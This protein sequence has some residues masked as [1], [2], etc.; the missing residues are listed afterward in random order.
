MGYA[1]E[2]EYFNPT[3]IIKKLFYLIYNPYGYVKP[4]YLIAS[5]EFTAEFAESI[6]E[7]DDS[8]IMKLG[9]P[10]T[11]SL[12]NNGEELNEKVNILINKIIGD[13]DNN[14]ILFLPTFRNNPDYDLF[15]FDF[16][17][18]QLEIFLNN[19]NL[20]LLINLHPFDKNRFEKLSG[21]KLKR[22]I[23]LNLIGDELNL[24]LRK[25]S[26]FITDYSSLWADFLIYNCPII[27]AQYDH[28]KYLTERKVYNLQNNLPVHI[29]KNWPELI[30]IMHNIVIDGD[31][32]FKEKRLA[33]KKKIYKYTNG[34]SCARIYD[35]V[36]ELV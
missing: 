13:I 1:S 27:F 33:M 12:L 10:K 5:S 36:N 28:D 4:S 3:S 2:D 15:K 20:L 16:D 23:M 31:D 19:N 21:K 29:V 32:I 6:Y 14:I 22:I 18:R 9:L 35:F 34:G 26:I 17:L 11:D 8:R 7:I 24:L 25:V 30:G